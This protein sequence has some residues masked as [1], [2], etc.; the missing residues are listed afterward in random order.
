MSFRARFLRA[1]TERSR[2]KVEHRE[3]SQKLDFSPDESGFE[4]T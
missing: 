4:M 3:K 1:V 2:S